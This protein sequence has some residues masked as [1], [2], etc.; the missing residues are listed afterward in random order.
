MGSIGTVFCG[1]DTLPYE[2][3]IPCT[4][5]SKTLRYSVRLM[6]RRHGKN[7]RDSVTSAPASGNRELAAWR[8]IRFCSTRAI[9]IA[10]T[11]RSQRPAHSARTMEVQ[12]GNR[13]IVVC[14]QSI[15]PIRTPRSVTVCID[16]RCIRRGRMSCLC[17][18]TGT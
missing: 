3:S 4:R 13:S 6:E 15:S 18:Y 7:S 12:R 2:M 5:E 10:S 16:W 11:S 1:L 8:S 17:S 9:L 14:N